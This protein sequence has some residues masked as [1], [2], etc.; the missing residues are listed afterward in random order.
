MGWFIFILLISERGLVHS[1]SPSQQEVKSYDVSSLEPPQ[2]LNIYSNQITDNLYFTFNRQELTNVVLLFDKINL[3]CSEFHSKPLEEFIQ[4]TVV[5]GCFYLIKESLMRFLPQIQDPPDSLESVIQQMHFYS[6]HSMRFG[7]TRHLFVPLSPQVFHPLH[8][9]SWR[10]T[11]ALLLPIPCDQFDLLSVTLPLLRQIY[12][13]DVQLW[14]NVH[15]FVG[16]EPSCSYP[17]NLTKYLS[18]LIPCHQIVLA[19]FRHQELLTEKF[20]HLAAIAHGMGSDFFVTLH[21]SIFFHRTHSFWNGAIRLIH[22]Q[23]LPHFMGFGYVIFPL[24]PQSLTTCLVEN[25]NEEEE[26]CQSS[27]AFFG[28]SHVELFILPTEELSNRSEQLWSWSACERHGLNLLSCMLLYCEVYLPLKDSCFILHGFLGRLGRALTSVS[29][30][31]LSKNSKY[32][33]DRRYQ[34][35]RP[36]SITRNRL[37]AAS[38]LSSTSPYGYQYSSRLLMYTSGYFTN[39]L[40]SSYDKYDT[41]TYRFIPPPVVPQPSARIA[42]ITAL[43]GTYESSPKPFAK[44]TLPV[45]FIC[46]TDL[47]TINSNGWVIDRTP[48]HTLI[49]LPYDSPV[50]LNSLSRNLHPMNVAK[51]YKAAFH[52]IPRLQHYDLI[53]W[54]DGNVIVSNST[55]SEYLQRWV[56]SRKGKGEREGMEKEEEEDERGVILFEHWRG[57]S[58]WSEVQAAAGQSKYNTTEFAGF[59]QPR[60][61]ILSQYETYLRDYHYL[62]DYWGKVKPSRPQYGMWVTCFIGFNMKAH[63]MKEFL[64]VWH[65]HILRYSTQ[66]QISFSLVTQSLHFHP[67]SLPDESVT[68]NSMVNSLFYKVDHGG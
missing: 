20:D 24:T 42:F 14:M 65:E 11:V 6:F 46:F 35:D 60:Q 9:F 51:F 52:F 34:L 7:A 41:D 38:W 1:T 67:T 59:T 26:E 50:Y 68:G 47:E 49:S 61:D 16:L 23:M 54:V 19:S 57:G 10:A 22:R 43:Y 36:V 17:P 33:L 4:S 40:S 62:A 56:S 48:Y 45:D 66:D 53:V 2:H 15:L 30:P 13:E 3:F 21:P 31:L 44:Q 63:R 32:P 5:I 55:T 25:M 28:R 12:L 58:L 37:L 39:P 27:V 8:F 64:T 29:D 18:S